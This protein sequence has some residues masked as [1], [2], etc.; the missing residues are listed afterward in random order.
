MTLGSIVFHRPVSAPQRD[1]RLCPYLSPAL[2]ESIGRV[3]PI[4]RRDDRAGARHIQ[5]ESK[6]PDYRDPGTVWW[7]RR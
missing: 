3:A 6:D 7:D 1:A 2:H 4:R 5:R